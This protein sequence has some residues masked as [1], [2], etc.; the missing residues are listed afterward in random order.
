MDE[1]DRELV[2]LYRNMKSRKEKIMDNVKEDLKTSYQFKLS[3]KE[4]IFQVILYTFP[5]MAGHQF[6]FRVS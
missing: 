5:W 2:D 3:L 6:L 4:K 1:F